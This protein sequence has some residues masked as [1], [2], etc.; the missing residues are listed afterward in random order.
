[1][2]TTQDLALAIVGILAN[3]P[4][5]TT[6]ENLFA[7]PLTDDERGPEMSVFVWNA[8]GAP[9]MK[10]L[11]GGAGS[12]IMEPE[13]QVIVRSHIDQYGEAQRL[14]NE[15]FEALLAPV[16]L[17]PGWVDLCAVTASPIMST[18]DDRRR[19]YWT[20]PVVGI[21]ERNVQTE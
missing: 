5:L 21:R 1:M 16:T 9:P 10:Y 18:G 15:V 11:D 7:R 8:G 4:G 3:V 13:A 12:A 19:Y 2:S 6:G 20:F 17:P 14:A